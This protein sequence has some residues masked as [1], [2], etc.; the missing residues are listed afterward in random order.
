MDAYGPRVPW[1]GGGLCGKDFYTAERAGALI[2]RRL[3]K[4]A[5]ALAQVLPRYPQWRAVFLGA[6]GFGHAAGK[7][8]YEQ[9]VYAAL[10][11]VASQVE[12]RGH[13]PHTEVMAT[14]AQASVTV[15]P[16]TAAEAFG[17]SAL[18]AMSMANA[19]IVSACGALPEIAG[20]AAIVLPEVSVA[21]LV[22]QLECLLTDPVLVMTVASACRHRAQHD[23]ALATQAAHLDQVRR[24]LL[25]EN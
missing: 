9:Q 1:G 11:T 13:V 17:R 18:E 16:S 8:A 4:L 5:Q 22:Q 12:F 15:M 25:G 23:F 10:Q 14:L 21:A 20:D 24:Q 19:V 3:A 6:W 2:A 7:S